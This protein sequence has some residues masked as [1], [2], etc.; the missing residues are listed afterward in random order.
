MFGSPGTVSFLQAI[1]APVALL[2]LVEKEEE[3]GERFEQRHNSLQP[4]SMSLGAEAL[5]QTDPFLHAQ[6][7]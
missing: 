5:G 6:L 7:S 2:H 3:E 4:C 1:S